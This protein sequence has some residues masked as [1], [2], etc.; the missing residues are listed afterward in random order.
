MT[1]HSER[2]DLFQPS[3]F[4]CRLFSCKL[5]FPHEDKGCFRVLSVLSGKLHSSPDTPPHYTSLLYKYWYTITSDS[6]NL[7]TPPLLFLAIKWKWQI[8]MAGAVS[9]HLVNEMA[10]NRTLNT[11]RKMLQ[12]PKI[13]IFLQCILPGWCN[14][15]LIHPDKA[16]KKN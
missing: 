7:S 4:S 2:H 15:L 1:A 9:F 10:A 3:H 6:L 13:L 8:E 12:V 11:L 14:S 16:Q 5:T